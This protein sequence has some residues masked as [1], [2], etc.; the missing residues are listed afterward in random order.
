[1]LFAAQIDILV[2]GVGTGGTITGSGRF[3]KERNPNIQ[4]RTR[5]IVLLSC[6]FLC[7]GILPSALQCPGEA[8]DRSLPPVFWCCVGSRA[9]VWRNSVC[10]LSLQ[11]LVSTVTTCHAAQL[12][13]VEPSESPVISGG[14]PGPHKIQGIG[15]GF[16]PGNLDT[17][18]LDETL[19]V[20]HQP[21]ALSGARSTDLQLR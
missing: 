3:L 1:M 21:H 2:A 15:A 20:T 9:M 4:V 8:C 11:A 14:N 6:S 5:L 19:Q 12:V 17:S 18:L 16:I 7:S 13:A 10:S